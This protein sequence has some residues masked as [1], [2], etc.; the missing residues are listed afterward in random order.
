MAMLACIPITSF[1]RLSYGWAVGFLVKMN[2]AT[3]SI[4]GPWLQDSAIDGTADI[5][6][7]PFLNPSMASHLS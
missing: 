7:P 6:R 5:S 2:G 4:L 3:I 1:L